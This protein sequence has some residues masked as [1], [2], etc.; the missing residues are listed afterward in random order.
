MMHP[1]ALPSSLATD[2]DTG[3]SPALESDAMRR[4][5]ILGGRMLALTFL[6]AGA[7]DGVPPDRPPGAAASAEAGPIATLVERELASIDSA[8]ASDLVA[9]APAR[10]LVAAASFTLPYSDGK[11]VVVV[12]GLAPGLPGNL[13]VPTQIESL[14]YLVGIQDDGSLKVTEAPA[15]ADLETAVARVLADEAKALDAA[16]GAFAAAGAPL[17]SGWTSW[18]AALKSVTYDSRLPRARFY[19]DPSW[20]LIF[21]DWNEKRGG[22]NMVLLDASLKAQTVN[23]RSPKE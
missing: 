16:A 11:A 12:V 4:I 10:K 5:S 9:G 3:S 1:A 15:R 7:A 18:R 14:R 6:A 13:P 21:E 23:G 19:G 20:S 2:A 22:W 17:P 8:T